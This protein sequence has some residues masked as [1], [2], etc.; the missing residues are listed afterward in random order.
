MIR[1]SA[2]HQIL[3]DLETQVATSPPGGI[4][5]P[6]AVRSI[7]SPAQGFALDR[8]TAPYDGE[9]PVVVAVGANYTQGNVKCPRDNAAAAILV[10]DDLRQCRQRVIDAL[11]VLTNQWI[12]LGKASSTAIG[13]PTNFHL[14]MTNFCLWN[15]EMK[16][17]S[18]PATMRCKLLGSNPTFHSKPT[19]SPNWP[20]LYE[21]K[22]KL[23]STRVLWIAHGIHSEVFDLFQAARPILGIRDW[24]MTPNLSYRYFHYEKCYPRL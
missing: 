4:P 15:T 18:I 12:P 3:L 7:L 14:V 13:F 23:Y 16:W 17:Q 1:Y 24:M 21:Q 19:T 2:L 8:E 10:E 6:P 20:H 11:D 22:S 5:R 9:L